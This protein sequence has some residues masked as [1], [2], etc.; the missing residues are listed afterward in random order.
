M[1]E[2]REIASGIAQT[3]NVETSIN[4]MIEGLK[5]LNLS[6]AEKMISALSATPPD[7][8]AQADLSAKIDKCNTV[9]MMLTA[10]WAKPEIEAH[11]ADV[12]AIVSEA[13][14]NLKKP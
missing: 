14:A 7:A 3:G 8:A 4:Q 5:S 2:F 11:P 6:L 12:E 9:L 1:D 10:V 13:T